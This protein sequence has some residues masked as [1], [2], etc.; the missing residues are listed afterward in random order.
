LVAPQLDGFSTPAAVVD[1]V[2]RLGN[3][4]QSCLLL[5]ALLVA[6]GHDVV[7]AYGVLVAVLP[8]LRTITTRRWVAARN[9]GVWACRRD[10]DAESMSA[11][12]QA[13]TTHAG[14]HHPRPARLILRRV[15]RRLRT[16][17][18]T[19]QRDKARASS[20]PDIETAAA[21]CPDPAD[22]TDE[23]FLADLVQAVRTRQL[24]PTTA[25][26]AYRVAAL[27]QSARPAGRRHD[28][29]LHQTRAALRIALD[30]LAGETRVTSASRPSRPAPPASSEEVH[31]MLP[32]Q[33]HPEGQ[34]QASPVLPLLLT[35]K[36]AAELLGIGR[37]TL[38]QLM[39]AGELRSVKRG[40]SRRI[41][42]RAVYEYVDRLMAEDDQRHSSSQRARKLLPEIG[43]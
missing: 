12:W 36:Q 11:A 24:D 33:Q 19:H 32:H 10:L 8:G 31:L 13:I 7:A 20:V 2:T 22:T 23:S 34:R 21:P 35:V 39:D 16:I 4:D 28:L 6:A 14:H 9:D 29:D 5:A 38:Y 40:A 3:P 27:G 17:H 37:S 18:D 41:P 43:A 1:T 26:V 15:E 42:L 25:A 30:V